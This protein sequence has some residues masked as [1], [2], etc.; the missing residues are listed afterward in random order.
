M[1][2][3]CAATVSVLLLASCL[4]A[5]TDGSLAGTWVCE[6]DEGAGVM[7]TY[8]IT[9]GERSAIFEERAGTGEPSLTLASYAAE[10]GALRMTL[11]N[12]VF[13]GESAA[14]P[15]EFDGGKLILTMDG[16]EEP[17]VFEREGR[18]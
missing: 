18:E 4:P 9:F 16:D 2:K 10:D 17:Y 11:R 13:K 7:W 6:R 15:Y 14:M 3:I 12:G 1:K 8:R 5:F